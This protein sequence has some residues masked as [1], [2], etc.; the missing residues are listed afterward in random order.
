VRLLG[1]GVSGFA[2]GDFVQKTLF[3]D[4]GQQKQRQLDAVAD[5]VRQK[6]G[7]AALGRGSGLLHDAKNRSE[8]RPDRPDGHGD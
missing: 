8:P 4:E 1:V 2:G 5:A 3:D 7:S 6:F